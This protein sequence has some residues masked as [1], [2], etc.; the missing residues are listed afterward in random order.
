M[1]GL[2]SIT[3]WQD[4]FGHPKGGLLGLFGCVMSIGSLTGLLILPYILDSWGRRP[5]IMFGSV[6]MLLGIGLQSGARN[7]GMFIAARFILGFGNIIVVCT[8]P[9]LITEIAPVQDRAILVT[10]AGA[11]YHS[12]AFIAAWTTYGTFKMKVR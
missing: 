9:L 5:G 7:F 4:Y 6:F 10:I 12:G 2:Q 11:T 3:Y 1:N 8:A